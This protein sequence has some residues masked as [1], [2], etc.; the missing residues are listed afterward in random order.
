MPEKIIVYGHSTCPGV[1][2]VLAMLSRV[3]ADYEYIN[4]YKDDAARQQVQ[5]INGGYESVPTV[6]F[7]NGATLTEPTAGDLAAELRRMGYH[8][9]V[10]AWLAGNMWW[11]VIGLGVL[12]AALRVLGVL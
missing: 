8:I 5:A 9:S 10:W 7:P 3:K 1:P 6:V 11:L 4:I 2:P 12:F